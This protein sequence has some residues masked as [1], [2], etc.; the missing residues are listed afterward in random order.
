[1][2]K[3]CWRMVGRLLNNLLLGK[4]FWVPFG[5]YGWMVDNNL[6]WNLTWRWLETMKPPFLP[7]DISNRSFSSGGKAKNFLA[8]AV[9]SDISLVSTPWSI[10]WKIPHSSHASTIFLQ[11]SPLLPSTSS[12]PSSEI[13]GISLLNS[14]YATLGRSSSSRTNFELSVFS[15]ARAVRVAGAIEIATNGMPMFYVIVNMTRA[16]RGVYIYIYCKCSGLLRGQL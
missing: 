5:I 12:I 10:T 16:G 11:I 9:I 7:P 13:T 15:C 2:R 14:L 4:L 8:W 3:I 1:M 6:K